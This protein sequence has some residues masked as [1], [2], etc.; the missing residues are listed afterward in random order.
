MALAGVSFCAVG[1]Q[2]EAEL[3]SSTAQPCH[4]SCAWL[5]SMYFMHLLSS[6]RCQSKHKEMQLRHFWCISDA[7]LAI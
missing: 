2:A 1:N 4:H 5:H 6:A 7:S 3:K